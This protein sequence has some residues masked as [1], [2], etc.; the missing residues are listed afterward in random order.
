MI[1]GE[2]KKAKK[3]WWCFLCILLTLRVV[4]LMT[5]CAGQDCKHVENLFAFRK[6]PRTMPTTSLVKF[7]QDNYRTEEQRFRRRR[8]PLEHEGKAGNWTHG[9]LLGGRC[10]QNGG[11]C[12]LGSFC[13]C[14]KAFSG[15]HCQYNHL[16]R[17]C[18]SIQHGEWA[19]KNCTWCK[20]NYGTFHCLRGLLENCDPAQDKELGYIL[21]SGCSLEFSL[22]PTCLLVP[23]MINICA[24]MMQLNY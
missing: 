14:P 20:C 22:H 12:V 2:G 4:K 13:V 15:R 8:G 24:R 19:R 9:V 1:W 18:N 23:L 21:T 10:C 5:A 6:T 11:T 3:C 17:D 16:N 7:S